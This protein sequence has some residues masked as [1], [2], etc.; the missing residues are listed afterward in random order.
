M[1]SKEIADLAGVTVRTLRHYHKIGLL[2]E[3]KRAENGYCEYAVDDLIRLL[4]IKT[5]ASLG[6]SLEDIA[7]MLED[8]EAGG[9]SVTYDEKLEELDR[10][11]AS[12]IERLEEQRRT[13][14]RLRAEGISPD[15]PL[16]ASRSCASSPTPASSSME[17][18][19]KTSLLLAAHLYADEDFREIDSFCTALAERDL[20]KDYQRA[21]K[22]LENLD[23]DS[24]AAEREQAE[25]EM[26]ELFKQGHR[27]LRREELG[28][29]HHRSREDHRRVRPGSA[30][31]RSRP[32][33][34]PH[35][36]HHV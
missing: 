6:F 18:V 36:R 35:T 24:S 7:S 9:Q 21:S 29:P 26:V 30:Q 8:E 11:L 3:P 15:I 23:E 27:L 5:L 28:S 13:V 10:E 16:R 14:A 31:P 19:D 20:V 4:R 32:C 12:Q 33:G 34:E 25:S 22:L 17:E 2:H 1:R